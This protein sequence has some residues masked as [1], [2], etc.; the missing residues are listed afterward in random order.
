MKNLYG[1]YNTDLVVGGRMDGWMDGSWMDGWMN[2]WMDGWMN[3]WIDVW[4]DGRTDGLTD[5]RTDG[6]MDGRTDGRTEALKF[7]QPRILLTCWSTSSRFVLRDPNVNVVFIS[8]CQTS[9]K[10]HLEVFVMVIWNLLPP[11]LRMKETVPALKTRFETYTFSSAY[12]R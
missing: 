2:G 10:P 12:G 7:G 6:R 8:P 4:M 3:E 11:D 5:G 9:V 1:T